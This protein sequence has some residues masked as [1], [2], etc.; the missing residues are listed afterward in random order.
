MVAGVVLGGE[1]GM[2]GNDRVSDGGVVRDPGMVGISQSPGLGHF[3]IAIG[4]ADKLKS[5]DKS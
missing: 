1:C 3:L 4:S 5:V 2:G